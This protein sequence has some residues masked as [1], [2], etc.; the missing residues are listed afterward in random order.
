M[1][2]LRENRVQ[3]Q[4]HSPDEIDSCRGR[5]RRELCTFKRGK[6]ESRCSA[7]GVGGRKRSAAAS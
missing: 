1:R 7:R 5:K 4:R 2:R 3:P 6:H